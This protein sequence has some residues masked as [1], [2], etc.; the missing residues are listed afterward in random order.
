MKKL[1][2]KIVLILVIAVLSVA[3]MG[4]EN[5]GTEGELPKE[6]NIGYL[7]VPNDEMVAKTM[8]IY[9]QYFTDQGITCNFIIFDSG[10]DANK[11]L[12]SGSID[13]ATMGNTNG[14]IALSSGLD[15]ELIWIHEVLGKIE[16]L[17]VKNGSNINSAENLKGQ[18]IATPFASTAHYS[19]LNYLKEAGIENDVELLD[20]QTQ[21]IVAA[22][23]R[24]DIQA[25]YSW[26]PTLGELLKNGSMLVSS[27]EMAEKG[28]VT[29]NV[30]LVRKE[31]SGKY[32][33]LVANFI[34]C[35]SEGGDTYRRDGQQSAAAVAKELEITPEEALLQME[36][37][38]WLTPQEAL[39][40]DYMGTTDT[41]GHFS[42]IM[43][44]TADF[45]QTQHSIEISPSQEAFDAFINPIYIEMS[46][47]N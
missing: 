13:F 17:A 3:L 24:G 38:L 18:K 12:A 39:G 25:A 30:C 15:V 41:P 44:D 34:K 6:V 47:E 33:E 32:P 10:V 35:L 27:E 9:D 23:E 43:K 45:L 1:T 31:F 7:R 8:G 42:K 29:A 11:A 46:L 36:G 22:W 19:L 28:Y 26:Q 21:D 16:G 14:I 5:G 2:A 4:C 20:M 40:A 37:S